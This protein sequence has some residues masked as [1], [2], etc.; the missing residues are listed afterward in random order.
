MARHVS[1]QQALPNAYFDALGLPR[2][3]ES[4]TA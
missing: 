1:V 3:A 4:L 2:L